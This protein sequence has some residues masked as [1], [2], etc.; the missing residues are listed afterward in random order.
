MRKTFFCLMIVGFTLIL[1]AFVNIQNSTFIIYYHV[2]SQYVLLEDLPFN[3]EC[4]PVSKFPCA[5]II[6]DVNIPVNYPILE[7]ELSAIPFIQLGSN[8]GTYQ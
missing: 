1:S 8:K 3:L 4:E 6:E 2:G 7:S 5:I